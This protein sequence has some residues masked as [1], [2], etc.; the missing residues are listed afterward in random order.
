MRILIVGGGI[1]AV[2]LAN[3]I[4]DKAPTS[5]VVIVSDESHPP[6]DRIHLC[7]L[8]DKSQ[9]IE[10]ITLDLHPKVRLELNQNITRI[11]PSAK[12]IFSKHAIFSYEKLIIAT[13]STP[14]ALFDIQGITNAS[15]FRSEHDSEKIAQGI[16]GKNVVIV[17][18]GPIGLELLDTLMRS[19]FP[20]SITLLA[21]KNYLYSQDLSREGVAQLQEIFEHD[22]RIRI[23]FNDEI[24]N[25]TVQK[26]QITKIQTRHGVIEDP[27]LIFGVGIDPDITFAREVLECDK[28]ILVDEMMCTSN[29]DIYCVGEAAQL[30]ESG[31][32]AGR[33]KEC[34]LQADVAVV[35]M[36]GLE[37][38][39][40]VQ[41]VSIDGLKV[42]SFLFAD[43]SSP[44]YVPKNSENETILIT[45]ENRIDQYIVNHDRLKRFIG[46]NTNIDLIHLKKLM[47][48]NEVID[49]AYLYSN[50]LN[51]GKGR[52][53][54]SCESVYEEELIEIIKLNAVT[55]FQEL[56]PF[57]N[58]GR[59]CGRCKQDVRS[60][61]AATP[62]DPAEA[63]R[64]QAQREEK[65]KEAE[66]ARVR[67]RIEKYNTI[68]PKN[69]LS[70]ENLKEAIASFD[71]SREF[72]QWVS[73]I[74]ATMH[75]HPDYEEVVKEGVTQLNK[76]PIIWLELADCSGNS[77]GFIK[78]S[79]PKIDDLILKYISLDYHELLMAGSGEQSESVLDN[80]IQYDSG[81]YILIVEGAVPLGLDGKY[82]RIGPKG[83]TGHAL[84]QRVAKNAAAVIAVGSCAYDGGVV[85]AAPNPTGA[86][87]VS[88]ALGRE[89][90]IN[91][92]GCPVNPINI[93][94]TLLHFMM[95]EE[96]P[97]LDVK[98]RPEW[99]YGFLVH[100]NC[101]R[102]GHF[103]LGEFVIEW[104]DE[105]AK[106]GWCLFQMGCKGPYAQMN[107]AQVKFNEGTSWP[108]Q[109]GHG[110]F[111]CGSGKIAFEKYANHRPLPKENHE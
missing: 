33:V 100:D 27:F 63:A 28:G 1:S 61:I 59:V 86:V 22:P 93:V 74:T 90:I 57:S 47:E 108:V 52:L 35:N 101:E 105:G 10:S 92:P 54:C 95:F 29:S 50:R 3:T 15:T 89:D 16:V 7:A 21:R 13:G 76:I 39:S 36:L 102:R 42:G 104:G 99:A 68:H 80:I 6:Y 56:K 38:K 46:I 19:P 25:K 79:H 53:V 91:L 107:C 5:E 64:L 20:K 31:F 43:V 94:G 37:S 60:L 88:E 4:M 51:S 30:R 106:K 83:E 44:D 69:Q 24:L 32:I 73:M 71:M 98:N 66:L 97:K 103:D 96:F 110:C 34:T 58:A 111:A 84:L 65:V 48:K 40:F 82:L 17:G 8:V 9:C 77:E 2:Y 75:L 41:E 23:W 81:K 87:G 70:T 85:A 11:D 18:V 109:V 14:K 72:N 55:S 12:R 49:A 62:V 26:D 78:S 67:A 45:H